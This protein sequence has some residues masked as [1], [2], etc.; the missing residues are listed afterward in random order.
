MKEIALTRGLLTLVDDEDYEPLSLY[1]WH[2]AVWRSNTYAAR[3][4]Y[5]GGGRAAGQFLYITL[6]RQLLGLPP[7]DPRQVDHVN[8]DGLDNRKANLRLATQLQNRHNAR[9]LG[10]ASRFIGV[11]RVSSSATWRAQVGHDGR[12]EHLGCFDSEEAAARAYDAAA[13]RLF[14]EFARLNFPQEISA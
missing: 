8:G 14:G 12:T 1:R 6:H 10:G 7:G 2:A 5:L 13:S 3:R 9:S 4:Q 11:C